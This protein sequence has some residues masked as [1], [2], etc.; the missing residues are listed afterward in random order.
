M[1]KQDHPNHPSDGSSN[2]SFDDF[3]TKHLQQAQVYLP[4][5]DFTA[6]VIKQLP[7][8]KKL[9]PAIALEKTAKSNKSKNK[10]K[11]ELTAPTELKSFS[12][13]EQEALQARLLLSL[14]KQVEENIKMYAE[15]WTPYWW[16][17]DELANFK[18]EN[19]QKENALNFLNNYEL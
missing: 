1:M 10:N 19:R 9:T 2:D 14:Q 11:K 5:D 6:R 3:L 4:D 8:P 17:E 12:A 16:K 15:V 13:T 18:A 7:A